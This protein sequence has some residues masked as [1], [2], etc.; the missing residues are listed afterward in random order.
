MQKQPY[1]WDGEA[2]VVW[3]EGQT[4]HNIPLNQ[5]LIQSKAL[6]LFKSIKAERSEKATEEKLEA[7]RRWFMMCKERSHL[8]S[9]LRSEAASPDVEA[10][11][12]SL[13]I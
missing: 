9:I 10:A 12:S 11:A 13:K 6:I 4:S 8:H 5:S 7:G 2:L 3:V 1:C